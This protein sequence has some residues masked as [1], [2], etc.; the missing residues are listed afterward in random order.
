MEGTVKLYERS[1]TGFNAI[2]Q[3]LIAA[4]FLTLVLIMLGCG[5]GSSGGEDRS[6][7]DIVGGDTDPDPD[8][9]PGPA[10][11]SSPA[12]LIGHAYSG[13]SI[14]LVWERD[15]ETYFIYRN[16]KK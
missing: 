11:G 1:E 8:P 3:S 12:E 6:V 16:G 14:G 7:P 9:D 15:G 4:F 5:S 13:T 10:E 2:F